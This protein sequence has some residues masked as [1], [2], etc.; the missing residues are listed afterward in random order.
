MC[1]VYVWNGRTRRE[2]N[3][4]RG[5]KSGQRNKDQETSRLTAMDWKLK[6]LTTELWEGKSRRR[7]ATDGRI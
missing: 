2:Q 5:S 4:P 7:S 1:A 3:L 6:T